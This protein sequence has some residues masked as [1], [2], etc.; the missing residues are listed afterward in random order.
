[1]KGAMKEK[2]WV[3]REKIRESYLSLSMMESYPEKVIQDDV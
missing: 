3:T 1:M 2:N